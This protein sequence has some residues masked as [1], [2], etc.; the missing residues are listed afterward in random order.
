M[1][2]SSL[3]VKIMERVNIR[4]FEIDLK[5]LRSGAQ[6]QMAHV[7]GTKNNLLRKFLALLFQSDPVI[8]AHRRRVDLT[9]QPGSCQPQL[10][11]AYFHTL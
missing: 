11:L 1:V 10:D 4:L 5:T 2:L 3:K 8:V 7:A 6:C 9:N